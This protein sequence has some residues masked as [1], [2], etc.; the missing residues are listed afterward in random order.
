MLQKKL[1]IGGDAVFGVEHMVE[2]YF[3]GVS[4]PIGEFGHM[5]Q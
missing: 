3:Q 1:L 5:Y 2:N 4:Q